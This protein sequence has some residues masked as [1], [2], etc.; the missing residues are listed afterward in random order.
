MEMVDFT[1]NDVALVYKESRKHGKNV[2]S[3]KLCR[4]K[5]LLEVR[6]I[7]KHK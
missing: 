2:I 4:G 1:K 6:I 7:G 3:E 5:S